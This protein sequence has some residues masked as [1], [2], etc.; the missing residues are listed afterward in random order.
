[1]ADI[2][3]KSWKLDAAGNFAL[4]SF[5]LISA[6]FSVQADQVI[7]DDLIVNGS[8]CIGQD[9]VNGESFGFDTIRLKE[10]NLRIRAVDSSSSSSF[11][12]N[13]WQI[14]FNDSANGGA[15]KFSIDDIDSGR[16]PF[17]IEAS[18]PSHSLYV[19]DGGRV[20]FGTS[21][22]VVDLH[23]K[24]GNTPTLRLEQ[25]GSSG[26]AAQTWDVAG[27]ETNFFIRDATNGS[28]LPFRIVSNA[29]N[30]SIF[31][32][33]DGDV[34]LQTT[35]PDGL[36]DVAHSSDA[37]NHAFFVGTDSYVGVNIDNGH[38]P[39]GL[40]D[41]QTTGGVSQFTVANDGDVGLGTASPSASMHV[42]RTDGSAQIFIEEVSGDQSVRNLLRLTNSGSVYMSLED[43]SGYVWNIQNRDQDF[44]ITTGSDGGISDIEFKLDADGNLT[45]PG[46]ITTGGSTCGG[47]CDIVFD[48]SYALPTIKQHA[49]DMWANRYLPAV[50]PTK[51][52][53]P[54]NLSK[55][56]GGMLNELETAHIY[57]EQLQER[58]SKLENQINDL[59][60]VKLR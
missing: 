25:D 60:T 48:K 56:M 51:E 58:I 59:S 37:N 10:N 16:T 38:V 42:R 44:R 45:I 23:V 13:D 17:T 54:I 26:F 30:A 27:N 3:R 33:A 57:I 22:P 29:P 4:I 55:K 11:P 32:A 28:K 31:V 49:E 52:N 40:F 46:S 39:A 43:N 19:D 41:V 20:G 6:P 1:M 2:T 53:V 8:A 5:L 12:T 34:G 35:T 7:L 18:A 9:C 21:T 36:F 24:S 47:G 14:T 15:N 50:G